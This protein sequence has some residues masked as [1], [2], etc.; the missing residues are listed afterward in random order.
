MAVELAV[1]Q[2]G[3]EAALLFLASGEVEQARHGPASN[4][5]AAGIG[6]KAIEHP[7]VIEAPAQGVGS[8]RQKLLAR[9]QRVGRDSRARV[10]RLRPR[11]PGQ[12]AQ[13]QQYQQQATSKAHK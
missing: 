6:F 5:F 13:S 10:K 2:H 3:I 1:Q 12:Q 7:L 9:M 11:R 8:V 4:G